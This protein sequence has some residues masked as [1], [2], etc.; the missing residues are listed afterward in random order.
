[1]KESV[2]K[3][4]S[5]PKVVDDRGRRR[6]CP[7]R[8]GSWS[9]VAEVGDDPITGRRKQ[10]K[11]GGYATREAAESAL[12][13]ILQQV[14][15]H[16]W[17][18]DRSQTVVGWL[19]EW[20]DRQ[21][22]TGALRP[23][24]V[25]AYRSYINGRL[26]QHLGAKLKLRDLKR[27][28]VTMLIRRM[29]D[30]GDGHTTVHRTIATLRSGLTAAV[31]AGLIPVNPA[32]DVDLPTR[33]V[34]ATT[35][36][37]P[38]ELGAFLDQ[39]QTDRLGVL[40]E[41]MAYTGLR[42][43]EVLGLTW[44]G[45][46]LP[47][48]RITVRCQIVPGQTLVCAWCGQGHGVA[49]REPKT[50]AGSRTVDIDSQTADALRVHEAEQKLQRA[51]WGH[52]YADHGLVF[53]REDGLPYHPATIT[54][55]FLELVDGMTFDG[56]SGAEAPLRRVRLHDLRH[57]AASLGIAA[58]VPIENISKRLGHSSIAVTSDIYGHLLQGVGKQAAEASAALVP[59]SRR[60]DVPKTV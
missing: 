26:T 7:K 5:C 30:A 22:K 44:D 13:S 37:E 48:G 35:P 31:R 36:W 45:V 38:A 55:R 52:A 32:K 14:Q 33:E 56:P 50:A 1:M 58:G 28:G 54:H 24:T 47:Y 40:F 34:R 16:G 23:S 43:G 42:R 18:D 46:D 27:P 29:I 2:T 21:E 15:D 8:H 51:A 11:R 12:T 6:T 20:T 59:R 41:V 19:T 25:A 4:C 53:A 9:Y 10:V 17:V 60:P 57:G 3:R 39:V 49:W